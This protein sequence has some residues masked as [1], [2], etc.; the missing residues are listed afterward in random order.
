MLDDEPEITELGGHTYGLCWNALHPSHKGVFLLS[1]SAN[2]EYS[3][4][5]FICA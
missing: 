4:M 5:S 3:G 1:L 2:G